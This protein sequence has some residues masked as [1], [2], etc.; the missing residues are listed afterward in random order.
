MGA[1]VTAPQNED[2]D[3]GGGEGGL[4]VKFGPLFEILTQI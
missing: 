2:M 3:G 4:R 1:N